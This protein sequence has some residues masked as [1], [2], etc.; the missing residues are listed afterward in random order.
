MKLNIKLVFEHAD[1][2][3]VDKPDGI[4]FHD[5][6]IDSVKHTGFFNLCAA[7]FSET[8]FPVHRLDKLTS[9]LLILARNKNAA[10]WFQQAFE[11]KQIQKYYLA[12]SDSKP[13]KKQGSIIG[14]MTKARLSQWKLL[15]TK[16]NPAITRFFN[17]GLTS[18]SVTGLRLFLVKPETGKT[19]QIRVALKSLGSAIL[20]DELYGAKNE[21]KSCDRGY[22]HALMLDFQYNDEKIKLISFPNTGSIFVENKQK[23][24]DLVAQ[25]E[26]HNWPK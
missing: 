6:D 7:H 8:L 4:G 2:Y 14:D 22:L 23:I 10:T 9:G 24:V 16:E 12:L 1:F 15:K 21:V 11:S 25:P 26:L 18:S 3:V 17:W 5:E 20:G 19:H 13:K